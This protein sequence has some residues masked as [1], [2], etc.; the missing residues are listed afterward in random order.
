MTENL[1]TKPTLVLGGTGKTG[2]RIVDR[3]RARGL[4]VRVG[5]RSAP[6]PFDWEYESNWAPVLDGVRAAYI[7]YFPDTAIPGAPE[8]VRAFA[9]L[10]LERGSAGSCCCPGAAKMRPSAPSA[11]SRRR[12]PT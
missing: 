5:S 2:R 1:Q 3:L 6:I 12:A 10:A 9:D 11:R 4:P 8:A 7:S